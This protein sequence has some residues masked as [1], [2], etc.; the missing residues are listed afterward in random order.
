M[1]NGYHF[2]TRKRDASRVNQ[3]SGVSLVASA[4]LVSSSK[5]KNPVFDDMCYYGVIVEIWLLDYSEFHIPVF[6]C[7]WVDNSSGVKTD[8]LGFTL[9]DRGRVGFK[10]EPFILAS[11]AKQVFY[12]DDKFDPKWSVVLAA[13]QRC[14]LNGEKDNDMYDGNIEEDVRPE[15]LPSIESFDP[16]GESRSTYM[17][18]DIE[19]S[20]LGS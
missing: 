5:D 2:S 15:L 6:K 3:N 20:W 9:V 18:E 19:G 12:V 7:E 14:Y 16:I 4:M 17:R 13:P 10:N 1:I 8:D 11:Q